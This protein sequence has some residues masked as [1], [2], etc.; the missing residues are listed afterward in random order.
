MTDPIHHR[1]ANEQDF[2]A[3]HALYMHEAVVPYLGLDPLPAE[4]FRPHFNELL[5]TRRFHVVERDGRLRGFYRTSRHGGRAAHVAYLAT[6]AV[7]PEL[8]GSGFARQM[9][10]AVIERL[11]REGVRRIELMVEADNLRGQAFYRKLGFE[12]EGILRAAYKRAGED[13]Y[14][15]EL[16][17]ARLLPPLA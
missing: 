7:A 16:Y 9:I 8:H 5:A 14:V 6:L 3:V 12:Q 11:H 17:F 2:E 10:E 13:G 4:A 1:L 15:D